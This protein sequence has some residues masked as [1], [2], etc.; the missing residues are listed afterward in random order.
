MKT[1]RPLSVSDG[2]DFTVSVTMIEQSDLT[3]FPRIG[4]LF[5]R[6]KTYYATFGPTPRN[7]KYTDLLSSVKDSVAEYQEH[8]GGEE[9]SWVPLSA[10][11]VEAPS[12]NLVR[13]GQVRQHTLE[14]VS[15]TDMTADVSI[16]VIYN[17][18]T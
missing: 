4:K 5:P 15:A 8:Q 10:V 3:Y 2:R 14:S 16:V 12:A 9:G 11:M 13:P 18:Q 17:E 7:Y 6:V 1:T